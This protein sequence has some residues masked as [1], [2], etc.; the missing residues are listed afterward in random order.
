MASPAMRVGAA[1]QPPDVDGSG[2]RSFA[3][4]ARK[5]NI[6]SKSDPFT[7]STQVKGPGANRV[8][9]DGEGRR[10]ST[11]CPYPNGIGRNSKPPML[12]SEPNPEPRDGRRRSTPTS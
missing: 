6:Q 9:T 1:L 5:G 3:F 4:Q 10:G 11:G 12:G 7:V 2:F 8:R